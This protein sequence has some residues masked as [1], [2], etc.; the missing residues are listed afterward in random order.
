[1]IRGFKT[2]TARKINDFQNTSG[3]SFWQPR[4]YDHIVRDE[5][6]LIRIREYIVHNPTQWDSDRNNSKNLYM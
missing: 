3:R 6:D 1:M 4:F 5:N 2:F